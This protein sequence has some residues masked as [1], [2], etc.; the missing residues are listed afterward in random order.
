MKLLDL[1]CTLQAWRIQL[2]AESGRL[3]VRGNRDALTPDV[4]QA[5]LW[6]STALM[7]Q[8]TGR[9]VACKELYRYVK[10]GDRV[11]TP[12]GEGEILQVFRDRLTVLCDGRVEAVF[13]RPEEVELLEHGREGRDSHKQRIPENQ[14]TS[15]NLQNSTTYAKS[16]TR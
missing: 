8:L 2:C 6:H 11:H 7:M 10:R 15:G 12:Y 9:L 3:R 16:E 13:C 5:I 4:Q 1:T 14:V